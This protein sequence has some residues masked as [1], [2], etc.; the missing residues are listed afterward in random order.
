MKIHSRSFYAVL[1]AFTA[2]VLLFSLFLQ[3]GFGLMPCPLCL[4]AR[5]LVLLLVILF[6][7]AFVHNP[8]KRGQLGYILVSFVLA[9]LGIL[10]TARHIW[11]MQLPP[12][13]VPAC[14]PGLDYLL[15]TLPILEAFL[16]ILNGSGEC[17]QTE[18]AF[19]GISLP[20]WTLMT[21]VALA[22]GILFP[23][24]KNHCKKKG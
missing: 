6:A 8:N 16:V 21:F 17:A 7:I 10:V 22:I 9:V 3:Y 18:G 15:E 14:T 12:A 11:M 2:A 19:L 13:L 20:A 4:I 1:F 23:L 5:F 24:F